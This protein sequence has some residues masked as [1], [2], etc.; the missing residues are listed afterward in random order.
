MSLAQFVNSKPELR[1]NRVKDSKL[2]VHFVGLLRQFADL[3]LPWRNV[4][5]KFLDLVVKHELELLKFLGFLL[6]A[7]DYFFTIA[8]LVVFLM[9]F[10]FLLVNSDLQFVDVCLLLS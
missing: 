6:K 1:I 5:F 3:R 7:V 9:N 8:D 10:F 2:V 4:T